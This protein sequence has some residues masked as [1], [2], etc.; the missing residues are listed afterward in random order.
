[1]PTRFF[2][3]LALLFASSIC[4][5]QTDTSADKPVLPKEIPSFD[6]TAMDKSVDPCVDFYQYSCGTW[7][8]NNPIP[9]D[10]A[11]W[12]RFS[13]LFERNLYILRDIL[14]QARE[15]QTATETQVRTFYASCMDESTIEKRGAAPLKPE[16]ERIEAVKS[17]SDLIEQ[18]A[19]MHRNSTAALFA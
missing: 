18:I 14:T 17:K 11:L 8:K 12:G 3:T 5:S 13:E 10:K 7:R 6:V 4:F 19:Y 15:T 9:P 16:M 1:M 2:C